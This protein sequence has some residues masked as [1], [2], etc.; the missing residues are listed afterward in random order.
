MGGP[1]LGLQEGCWGLGWEWLLAGAC[2]VLGFAGGL[3][4]VGK[5]QWG[6]WLPGFVPGCLPATALLALLLVLAGAGFACC[7]AVCCVACCFVLF[8][9]RLVSVWA[10]GRAREGI[11]VPAHLSLSAEPD[12]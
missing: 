4:V 2:F 11:S 7:L 10:K 8:A 1:E 6:W 12:T 5:G 9:W 3:L